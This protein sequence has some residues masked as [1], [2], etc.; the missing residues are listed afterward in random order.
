VGRRM[1]KCLNLVGEKFGKLSVISRAENEIDLSGRSWVTWNCQCS[2]GEKRKVKARNLM[3]STRACEKCEERFYK[4]KSK[5]SFKKIESMP[6]QL[7]IEFILDRLIYNYL[8]PK[9]RPRNIKIWQLLKEVAKYVQLVKE[10]WE[11]EYYMEEK[12]K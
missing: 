4:E 10:Q 6:I 7:G 11:M 3:R 5:K 8:R 9:I 1:K 2:C 12:N